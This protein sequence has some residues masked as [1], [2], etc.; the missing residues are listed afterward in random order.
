MIIDLGFWDIN[1][2]YQEDLQEV[3][4]EEFEDL[5]KWYNWLRRGKCNAH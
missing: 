5:I 1:G 2:E 4:Q 3:S